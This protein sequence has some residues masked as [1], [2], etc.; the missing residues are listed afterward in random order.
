M[1]LDKFMLDRNFSYESV[2]AVHHD[3]IGHAVYYSCTGLR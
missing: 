3:H 1:G 2:L